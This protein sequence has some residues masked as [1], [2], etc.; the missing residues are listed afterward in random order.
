MTETRAPYHTKPTARPTIK[1]PGSRLEILV[2]TLDALAELAPEA[3][4]LQASPIHSALRATLQGEIGRMDLLAYLM[5]A[6]K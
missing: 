6:A 2:E 5:S 4:P 1:Y 3:Y